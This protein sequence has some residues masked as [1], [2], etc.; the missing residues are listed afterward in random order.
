MTS[1]C[2]G[3]IYFCFEPDSARRRRMLI[4]SRDGLNKGDYLVTVAFTTQRLDERKA[5]PNCVYFPA[6]TQQGLVRDC[7]MQGESIAL[8]PW[9]R[10]DLEE[11]LLG[12][13]EESKL[14]EVIA[15]I[16]DIMG[17]A[18]YRVEE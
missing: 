10:F 13:I 14:Q 18:C 6:G 1:F 4:I 5:L 7:V 16:G 15:A 8:T 9:Q 3:D 11:G 17:A 2:Q 12:R